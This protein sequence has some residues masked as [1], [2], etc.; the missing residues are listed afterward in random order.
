[1]F[2]HVVVK[3]LVGD[4][5]SLSNL[6]RA[7]DELNQIKD[8][9]YLIIYMAGHGYVGADLKYRFM[10]R[11]GDL[12]RLNASSLTARDLLEP[13]TT[14]RGKKLMLVESCHAGMAIQPAGRKS[15]YSMDDALNNLRREAPSDLIIFGASE[16]F[17]LARFDGRWKGR[18]AFTHAL[19]EAIEESKAAD[20]NGRIPFF[21]FFNICTIASLR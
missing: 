16:G 20:I 17:E 9:D 12:G 18:G 1:M 13:L 10:L 3:S 7:F 15:G 6:R 21:R 11:S 4:Q 19:I 2:A 8:N 14:V 5:A